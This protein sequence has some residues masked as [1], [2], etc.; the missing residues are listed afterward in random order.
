MSRFLAVSISLMFVTISYSNSSFAQQPLPDPRFNQWDKNKDGKLARDELPNQ[1]QRNFARVDVNSDGFISLEEHLRFVNRGRQ[2]RNQNEPQR[3][4]R[5]PENVA[6]HPDLPY[7]AT[8]N[9]RQKLDLLLPKK[10]NGNGPLPVVAFIHGGGWRNGDKRG[11]LGR[12]ARFVQSGDYAAASI[13]YRL[14]DEAKWPAQIHDCKAAIRWLKA[15]A[16]R[17]NLDPKRIAVFGTSAGGH[18]VAMLGVTG[19]VEHLQGKLGPHTDQDGRVACVVDFFGPTDF[20]TM[21]DFSSRIDHDAANS[22][23]SLLVGGAIQDHKEK[24]RDAAPMTYISKDDVPILIM[25]GTKDPLVP[26]DQS[27]KFETALKKAGVDAVLVTITDGEHG[28][29]GTEIDTRVDRFLEKHLLGKDVEISN[30]AIRPV[31]K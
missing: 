29:R 27:V 8:D 14:S 11:G 3:F 28:F 31:E 26:F 15:N 22:P 13:G 23:E 24:A 1:L 19:G 25:H 10:A 20:L 12:V 4:V 9:P 6:L 21:N 2:T 5:T 17:Y 30:D 18:L 16:K 7:A